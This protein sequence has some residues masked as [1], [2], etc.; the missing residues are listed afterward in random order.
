MKKAVKLIIILAVLGGISWK[1]YYDHAARQ[2]EPK[3]VIRATGTIE[4]TKVEISSKVPG[5]I[6][7]LAVAESDMVKKG[8][9]MVV[10]DQADIQADLLQSEVVVA[11][12]DTS[13]SDLE[14]GSRSQEIA[15]AGSA[16]DKAESDME[17]AQ[18][19]WRRYQQLYER[20]IVPASELDRTKNILDASESQLK[21]AREQLGLL[22]E[23]ARPLQI[24][25]AREEAKR[26]RAAVKAVRTRVAD[27]TIRAPL[28]GTVLSK[29]VEEGEIVAAGVPIL[30]AADL[31]RPWIRVYVPEDEVGRVKLGQSARIYVDSAPGKAFSGKVT[32]IND[33]AE[34]TPKNIQTR[35]ERVNLV[36]G[37]KIA[38]ENP[39][40]FLKPGMPAD[41]EIVVE[42]PK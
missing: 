20:G 36:F 42:T 39:A 31:G 5:R 19:D 10:L 25:V 21:R 14:A 4:V 29:Y 8:Q 30:T 28:D 9:V 34:F 41:A 23:G 15:E 32:Q 2:N 40:G 18:K 12:A 13:A 27:R 16:V 33:E 17:K 3:N 11:K 35:R 6:E 37:V 7:K 1:L 26:A 38:L 22:R 24:K